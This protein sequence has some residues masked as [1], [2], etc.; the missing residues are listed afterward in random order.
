MANDA[1]ALEAKVN[2]AVAERMKTLKWDPAFE[3]TGISLQKGGATEIA[4]GMRITFTATV[5][6]KFN[7]VFGK[8]Q[9][10]VDVKTGL[11]SATPN[12]LQVTTGLGTYEGSYTNVLTK[13]S[14]AAF[15]EG[16]AQD[17]RGT[18]QWAIAPN[19]DATTKGLLAAAEKTM[20]GLGFTKFTEGL[21]EY[22]TA[23]GVR[24]RF[25]ATRPDGSAAEYTVDFKYDAAGNFHAERAF[26]SARQ[27]VAVS[28]LE[29]SA[30]DALQKLA[31]K[32]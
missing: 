27:D 10:T 3:A 31:G 32:L 26:L 2:A 18:L 23:G 22:N 24:V 8:Q 1:T 5:H 28:D 6:D 4:G 12:A 19:A 16:L 29:Q 14:V 15:T 25:Q 13:E 11:G 30:L 17:L 7:N 9:F 21:V 20:S